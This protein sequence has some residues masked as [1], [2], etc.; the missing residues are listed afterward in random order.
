MTNLKASVFGS[1]GPIQILGDTVDKVKSEEVASFLLVFSASI[2][3]LQSKEA[4]FTFDFN[5]MWGFVNA[6]TKSPS[7]KPSISPVVISSEAISTLSEAARKLFP[8]IFISPS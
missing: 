4:F 7:N 2:D 8:L 6:K 3:K 1:R 5:V